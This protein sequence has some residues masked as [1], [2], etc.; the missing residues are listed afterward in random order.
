[1]RPDR[2]KIPD[3]KALPQ[4]E[5]LLDADAVAPVLQRMLGQDTSISSVRIAYVRYRPAK[6]LLVMY[7]LQ[8]GDETASAVAQANS[9]GR[10]LAGRATGPAGVALAARVSGR[11]LARTPLAYDPDLEALIQWPPLDLGLPALAAT[12]WGWRFVKASSRPTVA[13]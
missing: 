9:G 6:R 10:D 7:E 2:T 4:I 13:A 1:M 5:R 3:D 11:S 8:C 12:V